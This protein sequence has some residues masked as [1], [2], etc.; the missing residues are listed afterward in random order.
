M[1]DMQERRWVSSRRGQVQEVVGATNHCQ[2]TDEF[3]VMF[4]NQSWLVNE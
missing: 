3:C 2:L 4:E 1:P